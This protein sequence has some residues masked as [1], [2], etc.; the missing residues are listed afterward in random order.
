MEYFKEQVIEAFKNND[1][2]PE[3]L[4]SIDL[5]SSAQ[6]CYLFQIHKHINSRSKAIEG[7][8]CYVKVLKQDS[9][10][11]VT[12][13]EQF[14]GAPKIL[15]SDLL[16]MNYNHS[17]WIGYQLADVGV[18]LKELIN[19]NHHFDLKA[20]VC[21]S[22]TLF[23]NLH[24]IH[25]KGYIHFNI[26]AGHVCIKHNCAHIIDYSL[27]SKAQSITTLPYSEKHIVH[28]A[29]ECK[30]DCKSDST[31]KC[32][33]SS[34]FDIYGSGKMLDEL[35]DRGL[36]DT[37]PIKLQ[38]IQSLVNRMTCNDPN[39]RPSAIELFHE[40]DGLIMTKVP[41]APLSQLANH[42]LLEILNSNPKDNV[43]VLE[44][45]GDSS[46][47]YILPR[48]NFEAAQI[49]R[50]IELTNTWI[51]DKET[52]CRELFLKDRKN[53]MLE[54]P[55]ILLENL[56][57]SK[58]KYE[59]QALD[60]SGK[61]IT[62]FIPTTKEGTK[63][64]CDRDQFE[65]QWEHITHGIFSKMDTENIFFAGGAV[66]G[67]LQPFDESKDLDEQLEQAGYYNSDIDV[68]VYGIDTPEQ[69]TLRAEQF[70]EEIVMQCKPDIILTRNMHT[71]TI[72]RP[73]PKRH[74][75]LIFRLYHSP[76]E[77]LMGF[78][79]DSCCVGYDGK[80]VYGLPRFIRSMTTGY[81][82]VDMSRRSPSYEYRLY[83]YSKR[84]FGVLVPGYSRDEIILY[85]SRLQQKT[86]IQ[87][88][89]GFEEG[90][91]VQLNKRNYE[92]M[93]EDIERL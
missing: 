46:L 17:E 13:A 52:T 69:A 38:Q 32:K 73:H 2:Y 7:E 71:L 31:N 74:I 51:S 78:D 21:L 57:E 75:Q 34:A 40:I 27:A 30:S 90:M 42:K 20:F 65:R 43:G 48:L 72:V 63:M 47:E 89:I 91:S 1:G 26:H 55:Y 80:N 14:N 62:F 53:K 84:G 12:I 23:L 24:D 18:S 82:V 58:A 87:R 61:N 56:F 67:A 8:I 86:G 29:P 4:I 83:K 5:V 22:R 25:A 77:I 6:D 64:I 81:N 92:N 66:L 79:I 60:L 35:L 9:A 54:N 33:Y 88:L 10:T 85:P 70:C 49:L 44:T 39:S 59:F 68:F 45:L 76:A 11:T 36:I 3:P 19:N 28:C 93:D 37:T 41:V 15:N 50:G 16:K